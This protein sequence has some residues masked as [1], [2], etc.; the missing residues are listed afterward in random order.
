MNETA[1]IFDST[2]TAGFRI[3]R[4]FSRFAAT[5]AQSEQQD[6]FDPRNRKTWMREFGLYLQRKAKGIEEA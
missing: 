3:T 1:A 2:G 4:E 6:F 5:I